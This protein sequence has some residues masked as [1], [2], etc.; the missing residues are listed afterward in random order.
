MNKQLFATVVAAAAA[1]AAPVVAQQDAASNVCV[2]NFSN[3]GGT[4]MRWCVSE[5]GTMPK[6]ESPAAQEHLR[7]G[8]FTEGWI[9]CRFNTPLQWDVSSSTQGNAGS[10]L[11]SGPTGT[12][13]TT[14]TIPNLA[15]GGFAEVTN[16]FKADVKEND[17]TITMTV[18]NV[19]GATVPS[20][21]VARAYDPDLNGT[22][23]GDTHDRTTR[24]IWAREGD[25]LVLTAT[26][27]SL[28]T[29]AAVTGDLPCSAPSV[30]TPVVGDFVLSKVAYF[31]GDLTHGSS[32]KVVF[33][34]SR[35]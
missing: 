8:I 27:F 16:L 31:I 3:G 10:I 29:R 22:T 23:F 5:S 1:M 6:F 13:V 34:Y 25:A 9:L 12:G 33:N 35:K 19:S 32:K 24:S 2:Y 11:V 17:I 4:G 30:A 21:W 18:K 26:T 28:L 15:T 20:V 7:I 14:R